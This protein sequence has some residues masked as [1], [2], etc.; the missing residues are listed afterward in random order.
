MAGL[1]LHAVVKLAHFVQRRQDLPSFFCEDRV[2]FL[3]SRRL[4][5]SAELKTYACRTGQGYV[6]LPN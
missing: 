1:I 3:E 6:E 5:L 2:S 4:T